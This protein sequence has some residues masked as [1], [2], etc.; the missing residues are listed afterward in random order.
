MVMKNIL[1]R[2]I[3]DY[4]EGY[5]EVKPFEGAYVNY[6]NKK[7]IGVNVS[8]VAPGEKKLHHGLNSV[9]DNIELKDGMKISFH[10]HLRNGDYVLNMVMDEIKPHFYLTIIFISTIFLLILAI[11]ILQIRFFFINNII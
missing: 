6:G 3:P 10:H 5:G 1:G 8:S 9:L 2:E 11:F 7:K 4:I